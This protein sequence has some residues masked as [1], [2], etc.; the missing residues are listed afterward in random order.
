M[1]SIR[2]SS[3]VGTLDEGYV[4]I[5]LAAGGRVGTGYLGICLGRGRQIPTRYPLGDVSLTHSGEPP[6]EWRH[7]EDTRLGWYLF[8]AASPLRAYTL[9]N[10]YFH[11]FWANGGQT[12]LSE[13]ILIH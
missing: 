12:M 7:P 13:A 2:V 3:Q 4:G 5:F 9:K 6:A 8:C 1:A 11:I 10:E